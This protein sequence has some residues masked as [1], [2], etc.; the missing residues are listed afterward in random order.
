MVSAGS[1]ALQ[2]ARSGQEYDFQACAG[3]TDPSALCR[4]ALRA[5]PSTVIITQHAGTCMAAKPACIRSRCI[6]Y[7]LQGIV[8]EGY[9]HYNLV[10]DLNS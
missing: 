10:S 4:T 9:N 7:S 2:P 6:A 1:I 5:F 8:H 3:R